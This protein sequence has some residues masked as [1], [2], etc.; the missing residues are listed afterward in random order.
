MWTRRPTSTATCGR[1]ATRCC[2]SSTGTNLLGLVK[3]LSAMELAYFR[4]VFDRP[5]EVPGP[6]Y[7]E[8][9]EPNADM[10]ATADESREHILDLYRSSC[11]L[12]D[13]TIE[14]LPLEAVGHVPWWGTPRVT[15]HRVLTH[16]IAETHRH[17]GHADI[18]RE[19]ID[20]TAGMRGPGDNV[21][22]RDEAWWARYR[23]RL[24]RL[25]G[26]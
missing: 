4:E 20:G 6:W 18:V 11:A 1:G 21:V 14:E 3:H 7:G 2:R 24:E 15:L 13:E 23:E 22:D 25:A 16:M 10:Y 9:A 26:G 17:A 19:L 5:F 12:S 8:D